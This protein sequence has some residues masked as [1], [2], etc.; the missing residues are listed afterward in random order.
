MKR[1]HEKHLYNV[2]D[3]VDESAKKLEQ[4]IEVYLPKVVDRLR[5]AFQFQRILKVLM[6]RKG[7]VATKK[8]TISRVSYIN[9][10][11]DVQASAV[12]RKPTKSCIKKKGN[13]KAQKVQKVRFDTLL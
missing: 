12:F 7:F 6:E 9:F 2:D 11:R 13:L 1:S 10:C 3:L 8:T 5:R 4:G